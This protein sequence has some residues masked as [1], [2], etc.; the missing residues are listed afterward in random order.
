MSITKPN[1]RSAGADEF[2]SAVRRAARAARTGQARTA[3]VLFDNYGWEMARI[4]EQL[5]IAP[6]AVVR[7]L[8][9]DGVR[10]CVEC[11][12][13]FHRSCM[14]DLS[15]DSYGDARPCECEHEAR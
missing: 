10:R 6:G 12:F 13:A 1:D 2:A 14:G 3:Q 9:F 4:S 7:L 15:T 11:S 5:D 8:A